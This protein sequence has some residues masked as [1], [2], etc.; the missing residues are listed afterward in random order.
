MVILD[1]NLLFSLIHRLMA[2]TIRTG[3]V[4]SVLVVVTLIVFLIDKESNGEP[5]QQ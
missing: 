2:S 1:T 3:T 5:I 4:T